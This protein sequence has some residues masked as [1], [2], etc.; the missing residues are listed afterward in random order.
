MFFSI[1]EWRHSKEGNYTFSFIPFNRN[2][3]TSNVK[4][5]IFFSE[6]LHVQRHRWSQRRRGL[7]AGSL[8]TVLI[9]VVILEG[10]G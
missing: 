10:L 2:F 7:G 1:Q 4:L 9:Q 8:Q 5:L 6:N 3:S